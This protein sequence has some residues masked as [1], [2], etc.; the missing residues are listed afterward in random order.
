[1][2]SDREYRKGIPIAE[3]M[4]QIVAESGKSFDPKVVEVLTPQYAAL[5]QRARMQAAQG[6]VLSTE[7]LVEKGSA[8]DAGLDLCGLPGNAQGEDFLA[9]ITAAAREEQL[10]RETAAAG[11]SLDTAEAMK[12]LDAAVRSKIPCDALVFFVRHANSL[13]AE[14]ASGKARECLLRLEVTL[15][16]G[17]TGWVGQNLQPVVNANPAVDPG[18]YADPAEPLQSVL[19]LPLNGSQGLAGVMALYRH[20]KDAFTRAEFHLA[21]AVAPNITSALQNALAHRDLESRANLDALTGAYSRSQ[22]LRFLDE[23]LARARRNEQ[24]VALLIAELPGYW[25]L[26]ESFGRSKMDGLLIAISTG[27]RRASREYDCLGRIAE[28]RFALVLPGM[29]PAYVVAILDRLHEIAAESGATVCGREI[30]LK[31]GGAFY[32]DDADGARN[33]LS[34]GERKLDG[35]NR[36]WEQSLRA[37]LNAG[38]TAQGETPEEGEVP[39]GE[40]ESEE[41][42]SEGVES[43]LAREGGHSKPR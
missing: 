1:M 40:L 35:P 43:R 13:N 19:A 2:I 31:L 22:L 42:E 21:S 10:L 18:F 25:E 6:P 9:T 24:P 26:A 7:V 16:D 37:L 4:K 34:V 30:D 17:L 28:N 33:L 27:L 36:H 20:R 3:A 41:V 23:E 5:E 12:R 29:K 39:S 38:E 32:P 15:G 14:F 8:P 11:T